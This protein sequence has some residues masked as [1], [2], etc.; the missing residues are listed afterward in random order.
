MLI[1]NNE[2]R[3]ESTDDVRAAMTRA[4]SLPC[5]SGVAMADRFEKRTPESRLIA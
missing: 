5:D 2:P 3:T 4:D 1:M